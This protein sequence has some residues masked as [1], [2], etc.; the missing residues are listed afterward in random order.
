M[1]MKTS[2]FLFT[3]VLAAACLGC[4]GC[5]TVLGAFGSKYPVHHKPP[6]PATTLGRG[7]LKLES[8]IDKA[9][10]QQDRHIQYWLYD[11]DKIVFQGRTPQTIAGLDAGK[12]YKI[13]WENR[14]G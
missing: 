2:R 9:Q 8:Y 10:L 14:G 3:V 11:S 13:V 4:M 12:R 7:T 5:A 1:Y 6:V